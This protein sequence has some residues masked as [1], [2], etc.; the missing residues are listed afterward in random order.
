MGQ[1]SLIKLKEK[2]F[3]DFGETGKRFVEKYVPFPLSCPM[4]ALLKVSV[5]EF[6]IEK[7]PLVVQR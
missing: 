4:T 1:A 2:I 7:M 5:I 6:P 3:T